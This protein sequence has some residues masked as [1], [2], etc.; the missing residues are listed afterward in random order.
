MS[1][2]VAK[3][4]AATVLA[5]EF[6]RLG[7]LGSQ[8]DGLLGLLSAVDSISPLIEEQFSEAGRKSAAISVVD[9][10]KTIFSPK[11]LSLNCESFL[12]STQVDRL[13]VQAILPLLEDIRFDSSSLSASTT[14]IVQEINDFRVKIH[15]SDGLS[16]A[17]KLVVDAQLSLM[18]RSLLRFSET[19][20][21]P[22]RISV[23]SSMGR[24]FVEL[25]RNP[26]NSKSAVKDVIDDVL[27]VYGLLEA[28]GNLLT[29]AAP[30]A[31]KLLTG[32]N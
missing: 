15:K 14:D 30:V 3:R 16:H 6:S 5:A 10:L 8:Y 25:Q 21:G 4:P 1:G 32:P 31:V 13:F 29:L 9:R 12:S 19:G 2:N 7:N 27:R 28:G 11:N 18:E 17:S 26:E 24:I 23:M 20:V 22:F